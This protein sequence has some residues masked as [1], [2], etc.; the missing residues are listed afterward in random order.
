VSRHI[1]PVG[2]SGISVFIMFLRTVGAVVK[3]VL[4]VAKL[5]QVAQ[6]PISAGRC[7]LH[8]Q[9]IALFQQGTN[10]KGCIMRP[11]LTNRVSIQLNR[12]SSIKFPETNVSRFRSLGFV[13]F[14]T[15]VASLL[16]VP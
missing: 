8:F 14:P 11:D 6:N 9:G 16:H 10:L 12:C 15:F 3:M 4:N 13:D 7:Q 1:K 5:P 2:F